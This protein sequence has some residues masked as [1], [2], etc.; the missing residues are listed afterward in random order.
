MSVGYGDSMVGWVLVPRGVL[1]LIWFRCL[2][3]AHP[4]SWD[5]LI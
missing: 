5:L 1:D 4:K 3:R 2:A